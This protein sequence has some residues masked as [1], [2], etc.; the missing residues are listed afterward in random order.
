MAG[1][2]LHMT[3]SLDFSNELK[4]FNYMYL[5]LIKIKNMGW[6]WTIKAS[7]AIHN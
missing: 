5:E 7:L 2:N 1:T 4:K 6:S 3:I